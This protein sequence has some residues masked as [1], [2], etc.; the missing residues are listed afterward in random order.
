MT[1][2]YTL[3]VE[4]ETRPP[5]TTTG[6]VRA[7]QVPSGMRLAV[8]DGLRRLRPHG[9]TSIVCVVE[10]VREEAQR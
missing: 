8:K 10:R 7:S 1:L 2:R 5:L 4:F 9:W 3:S 6:E